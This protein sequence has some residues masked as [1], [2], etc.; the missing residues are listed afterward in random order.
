[1]FEEQTDTDIIAQIKEVIEEDQDEFQQIASAAAVASQ[2]M[3]A[4]RW[5]EKQ[6]IDPARIIKNHILV[7][8]DIKSARG[9]LKQQKVTNFFK[10]WMLEINLK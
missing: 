9:R 2:L 7:Q 8:C 10:L 5:L 6:A 4:V 3:W 1:M